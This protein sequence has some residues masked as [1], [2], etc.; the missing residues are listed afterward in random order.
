M[1]TSEL[2]EVMTYRRGDVLASF[3]SMGKP[4]TAL[5]PGYYEV[6]SPL[7]NRGEMVILEVEVVNRE[8]KYTC[9][10][11]GSTNSWGGDRRYLEG[12]TFNRLH[13]F[14]DVNSAGVLNFVRTK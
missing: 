9:Y 12:A 1:N 11:N 6:I 7:N 8:R 2:R 5:M 14:L 4:Y 10:L 13:G 3:N